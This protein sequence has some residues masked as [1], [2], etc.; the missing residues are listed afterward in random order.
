MACNDAVAALMP[1]RF[2]LRAA[3]VR[4]QLGAPA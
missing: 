2:M 3:M 1:L 4:A